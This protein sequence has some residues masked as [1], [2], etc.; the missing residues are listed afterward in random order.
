MTAPDYQL[1]RQQARA[2]LED[3]HDPVTN[4]ANLAALIYHGVDRLNWVGFYF[5]RDGELRLGPFQGQ[6]ACTRIAVDSGVCGT[7]VAT[8][9]TQRVDDVER[10]PG[11]IA[12]D[13]ASRSE[14][15]VPLLTG[16]GVIGVLDIDSPERGRFTAADQAGLEALAGVWLDATRLDGSAVG[17]SSTG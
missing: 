9:A 6:P 11:H 16:A 17:H 4:A 8:R 10:F 5:M 1:L 12:C 3:E 13:A 7:A 14:L 15:V 2:L